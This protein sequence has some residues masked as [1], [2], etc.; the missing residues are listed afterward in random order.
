MSYVRYIGA[1]MVF[2][3]GM[4]AK[5]MSEDE[6]NSYPETWQKAAIAGG[7]YAINQK[8]PKKG[9]KNEV[10]ESENDNSPKI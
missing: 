10:K 5:D 6:W 1:G 7:V 9:P 8:T 2:F 3:S 4:P